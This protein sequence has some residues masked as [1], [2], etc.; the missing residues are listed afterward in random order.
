[1]HEVLYLT[2]CA[3]PVVWCVQI[4]FH[5]K[6]VHGSGRNLSKRFRR[7]I[8]CHYVSAACA[9]TAP[10][11]GDIQDELVDMAKKKGFDVTMNQLWQFRSRFIENN[12]KAKGKAK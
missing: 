5:S 9:M 10:V 1:L 4:F 2:A 8:S 7:A 11:Q 3:A 6:L 12:T